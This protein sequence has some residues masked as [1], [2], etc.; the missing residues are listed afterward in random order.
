MRQAQIGDDDGRL[1]AREQGLGLGLIAGFERARAVGARYWF[2][3]PA[4]VGGLPD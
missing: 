1:M 2:D 4:G 3:P